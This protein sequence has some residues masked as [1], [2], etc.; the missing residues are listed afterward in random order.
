MNSPKGICDQWA[1]LLLIPKADYQFRLFYWT[2]FFIGYLFI[3]LFCLIN[4]P[5]I[6]FRFAKIREYIVEHTYR[7]I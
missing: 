3:V 5:S 6:N 4:G 2:I 1:V 7:S